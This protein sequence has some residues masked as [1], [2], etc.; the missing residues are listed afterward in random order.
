LLEDF[1]MKSKILIVSAA[2]FAFSLS[3]CSSESKKYENTQVPEM[4]TTMPPEISTT[5]PDA[6]PEAVKAK[7]V[8]PKKKTTNKKKA[9]D[10]EVQ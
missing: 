8:T 9:A 10:T 7:R 5:S 4:S 2:L 6:A 1:E 3:A